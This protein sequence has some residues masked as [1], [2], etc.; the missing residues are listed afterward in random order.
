[1][2]NTANATTFV[3][4][5]SLGEK[6]EGSSVTKCFTSLESATEFALSQPNEGIREWEIVEDYT[7]YKGIPTVVYW[8]GSSDYI[9]IEKLPLEN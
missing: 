5:V 9:K 3:F 8:C 1:M 6:Y 7:S 2:S 4:V